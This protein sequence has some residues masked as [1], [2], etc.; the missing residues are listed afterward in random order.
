MFPNI[1]TT[2]F[3]STAALNSEAPTRIEQ[4]VLI[5][6]YLFCKGRSFGFVLAQRLQ[7]GGSGE[8]SLN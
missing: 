5:K 7:N 3:A 1:L 8:I 6:V 4:S 2:D